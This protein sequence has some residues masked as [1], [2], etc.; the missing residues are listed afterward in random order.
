M[1]TTKACFHPTG[2]VPPSQ[3]LWKNSSRIFRNDLGTA[4]R[5]RYET[6]ST[7]VETLTFLI[8][9]NARLSSAQ[10]SRVLTAKLSSGT[11]CAKV[12]S[13]TRRKCCMFAGR[14]SVSLASAKASARASALAWAVVYL[15]LPCCRSESGATHCCFILLIFFH[16]DPRSDFPAETESEWSFLACAMI[17]LQFLLAAS[18]FRESQHSGLWSRVYTLPVW[19][20]QPPRILCST[21]GCY[22]TVIAHHRSSS[23]EASRME[24]TIRRFTSSRSASPTL[25]SAAPRKLLNK[26]QL[27]KS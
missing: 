27:A 26:S 1:G 5:I 7:P 18:F 24:E 15:V 22:S 25:I 10:V 2:I 16:T 13:I 17:L 3:Y 23:L 11:G 9:A 8:K 4:F 19:L 12:A 14:L 20:W 21:K 6:V